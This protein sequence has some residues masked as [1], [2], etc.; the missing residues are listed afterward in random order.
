MEIIKI[1]I[2]V[3]VFGLGWNIWKKLV[4][5]VDNFA[6]RKLSEKTYHCIICTLFVIIFV[7]I[8]YSIIR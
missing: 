3:S 7:A 1:V 6:Q 8:I 2:G 5:R 4:D